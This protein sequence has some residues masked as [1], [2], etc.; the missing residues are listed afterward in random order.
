MSVLDACRGWTEAADD[1]AR[2]AVRAAVREA[3]ERAGDEAKA[4]E[5]W[6][7][8]DEAI[9]AA[10]AASSEE[11][12]R[13]QFDKLMDP[14]EAQGKAVDLPGC[15]REPAALAVR[16][17]LGSDTA[18]A[19]A[20]ARWA[21]E[22]P[23]D[24]A[25]VRAIG[26]DVGAPVQGESGWH[27]GKVLRTVLR[28]LAG[29]RGGGLAK[30]ATPEAETLSLREVMVRGEAWA[31][32]AKDRAWCIR[33]WLP[34]GELALLAAVGE[35]GKSTLCLQWAMAFAVGIEQWAASDGGRSRCRCSKG[36]ALRWWRITRTTPTNW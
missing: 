16:V 3:R 5:D 21:V 23:R 20:L 11:E 36:R 22:H 25:A 28:N 15:L 7:R 26:D 8:W 12:A 24:A 34:A 14:T 33:D 10:A 18:A 32:E 13:K 31:A 6:A 27:E 29:I 4:A 1:A 17:F 19:E 9:A 2:E 35:A 30:L